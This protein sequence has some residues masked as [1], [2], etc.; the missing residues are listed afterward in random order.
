MMDLYKAQGEKKTDWSD[1]RK[2]VTEEDTEKRTLNRK[3]G[4][5]EKKRIG[6]QRQNKKKNRG[7]KEKPEQRRHQAR[8]AH[9]T[10]EQLPITMFLETPLRALSP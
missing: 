6:G 9:S 8:I 1:T 3:Q 10:D 2:G 4:S 7:G 5:Q